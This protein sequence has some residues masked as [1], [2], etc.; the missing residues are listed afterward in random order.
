MREIEL[1]DPVVG[2]IH[3]HVTEAVV[4]DEVD[5]GWASP[6]LVAAV[7][8]DLAARTLH[9]EGG[10]GVLSAAQVWALFDLVAP[11]S[12]TELRSTTSGSW[13]SYLREV[14]DPLT[15]CGLVK[16]LEPETWARVRDP[17]EPFDPRIAVELK[18]R[19]WRRALHQAGRYKAFAEQ[20]FIAMP[21]KSISV[22]CA[23]AATSQGIGVIAVEDGFASCVV[24]AARAEPFDARVRM[25]VSEMVFAS[26]LGLREHRP[27]GSPGGTPR[28]ATV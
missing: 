5:L 3:D 22:G 10:M 6:D 19:D 20:V 21:V 27:A 16:T 23:T 7:P 12:R 9:G 2:W 15:D 1:R 11:R 13:S 26:H 8:A 24:Q 28:C 14:L 18:I 17:H 4:A 25:L